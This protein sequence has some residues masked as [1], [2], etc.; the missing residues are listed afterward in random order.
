MNRKTITII[1]FSCFLL[2][3][4][5]ETPG[6]ENIQII[7]HFGTRGENG[8]DTEKG[9]FTLVTQSGVDTTIEVG[10]SD[11]ERHQILEKATK[12]GFFDMPEKKSPNERAESRYIFP[13]IS[14]YLEIRSLKGNHKLSWDACRALE[15][16][17]LIEL[18]EFIELTVFS[19][20]EVE[21]LVR[22]NGRGTYR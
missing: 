6:N 19:K 21:E 10:L 20:V 13:C 7:Y 8:F 1:F 4:C 22:R 18:R 16:P 14:Y 11:E 5:S 17:E 12:A 2:G 3:S 15:V 9:T